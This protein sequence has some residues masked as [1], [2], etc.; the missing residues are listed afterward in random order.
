MDRRK[1]GACHFDDSAR[2]LDGAREQS[3]FPAEAVD[4]QLGP[5]A[6]GSGFDDNVCLA[7]A[8]NVRSEHHKDEESEE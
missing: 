6:P 7:D 2:D 5:A 8:D 3:Q 1:V 4:L